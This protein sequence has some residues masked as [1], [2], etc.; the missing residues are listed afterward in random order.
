MSQLDIILN[1]SFSLVSICYGMGLF[2]FQEISKSEFL[3][4][5]YTII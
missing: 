5:Y 2:Q 4:V 1:T 3:I